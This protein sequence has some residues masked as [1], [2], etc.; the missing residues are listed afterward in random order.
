MKPRLPWK[1]PDQFPL[2]S[3]ALYRRRDLAQIFD[4][5]IMRNKYRIITY[6]LACVFYRFL[7]K[8]HTCI[9]FCRT[10]VPYRQ[11]VNSAV[12]LLQISA[13]QTRT[14][15]HGADRSEGSGD[16]NVNTEEEGEAEDE[17]KSPMLG[18]SWRPS[19]CSARHRIAV[20]V[21]YRDRQQ[22]LR[23]FLRY[24]HPFLQRQLL[25][26]TI[27][28]VEQVDRVTITWLRLASY[29]LWP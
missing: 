17:G 2:R 23:I 20:V 5:E 10:N 3:A 15:R 29:L 28:V 9:F 12:Y 19:N 27:Y 22:H 8:I 24:M 16:G 25:D 14:R 26:Y 1:K 13:S 4:G 7:C 21:P 11:T 18:G 6:N